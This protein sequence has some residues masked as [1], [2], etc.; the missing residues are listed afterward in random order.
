MKP[1]YFKAILLSLFVSCCSACTMLD[2]RDTDFGVTLDS[3]KPTTWLVGEWQSSGAKHDPSKQPGK[4]A[5][6]IVAQEADGL[7]AFTHQGARYEARS[8]SLADEPSAAM[9]AMNRVQ[10]DGTPGKESMLYIAR[11]NDGILSMKVFGS[12]E[13]DAVCEGFGAI[14]DEPALYAD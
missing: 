8:I 5:D 6:W 11:V 2:R 13:R 4:E 3:D 14:L 7:L 12:E 9:L 10:K 1:I